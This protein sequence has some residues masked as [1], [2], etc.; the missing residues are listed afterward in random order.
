MS[1][2][3]F[4]LRAIGIFALVVGALL[5]WQLSDILLLVFGAVIMAMMLQL[6]ADPIHRWTRLPHGLALLASGLIVLAVAGGALWLFRLQIGAEMAD[7]VHRATEA[8]GDF[9]KGLQASEFGRL[10]LSHMGDTKI[11]VSGWL[12]SIAVLSARTLTALILLVITAA[13]LTSQPRLYRAGLIQLFPPRLHGEVGSTLDNIGEALRLWLLGQ[14]IQMAIIG[15]LSLLAVWLIGL[16]SALALGLIAGICEFIP[17]VGPIIAGIPAV[18][19]GFTVSLDAALW[20]LAAYLAIHQIEGNLVGPLIQR[21]MVAIPPALLIIVIASVEVLFGPI[22]ILFAAPLS[23]V[24]FV[25]VK[26]IYVRDTLHEATD[27]PGDD[28]T[29]AHA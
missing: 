28:N 16:P 15:L 5:V 27:I 26:R 14:F 25:A 4:F 9:K 7:V 17:Y 18:L 23:V 20:T 6:L 11:S 12:Q 22:G 24:I 8:L 19:V 2:S 13:Y 21:Y 1:N 10:I 29:A 3:D